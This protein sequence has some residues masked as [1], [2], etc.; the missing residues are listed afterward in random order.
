MLPACD[1]LHGEKAPLPFPWAE[2]GNRFIYDF[3]PVADSI[4]LPGWAGEPSM[5]GETEAALAMR[6][7]ES[8][9]HG[10]YAINFE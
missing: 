3:I 9:E 4:T 1:L 6:L 7:S 10:T 8:N 5:S 2:P